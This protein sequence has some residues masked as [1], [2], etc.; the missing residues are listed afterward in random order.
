MGKCVQTM[1]KITP[2]KD[3]GE[4]TETGLAKEGEGRHSLWS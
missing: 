3:E 1:T 4:T 2:S